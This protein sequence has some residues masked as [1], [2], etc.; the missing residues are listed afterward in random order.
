[1]SG[2][3]LFITLEGGEGAGKSTQARLLAE[4]LQKDGHDVCLTREPGGTERAESLREMLLFGKENLHWKTEVMLIMAARFDHIFN[5]ISPALE[6]GKIVICDRFHDSTWAYQGYG[7]C[8]RDAEVLDFI[9]RQRAEVHYEP[10]LTFWLDI[11]VDIGATRLR[12]R[13]GRGD[14]YEGRDNAFHERVRC[15][16]Q[17]I[18]EHEKGYSKRILKKIDASRSLEVISQDLYHQVKDILTTQKMRE[19]NARV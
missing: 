4:K 18:Y 11:S 13:G 10:A 8:F 19:D 2:K 14:R 9:K 12:A 15:G 7:V 5:K 17:D 16:F 6:A 1:M 3:G